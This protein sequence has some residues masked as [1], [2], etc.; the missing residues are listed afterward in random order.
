MYGKRDPFVQTD[1]YVCT[2]YWQNHWKSWVGRWAR[3]ACTETPRPQLILL[4]ATPAM[5]M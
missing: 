2:V 1:I 4:A 3:A 5:S